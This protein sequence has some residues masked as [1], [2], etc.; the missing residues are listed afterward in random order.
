MTLAFARLPSPESPLRD[1]DP[2]WKL[3]T[4]TLLVG[5][6]LPLRTPQAAG[7]AF[8]LATLLALLGRVPLRWLG[9]RLAGAALVLAPFVLTLPWLMRNSPGGWRAGVEL[10]L[11]VMAKAL[12][13]LTLVLTCLTA[14]PLEATLKAAH[15]LKVPGLLVQLFLLT[16]RYLFLLAEELG[17]LRTALRARGYR[18]RFNRHSYRTVGQ[19]A[20]SLLVRSH[21]RGERVSQAMRC[22]GFD[23]R[24]RC[25]ADFHSGWREVVFL[26]LLA[27]LGTGLLMLDLILRGRFG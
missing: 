24:F 17:R 19:V 6:T 3:A 9:I 20:G 12:T 1:L 7:G 21:E 8:L 13:V 25:L 18:N 5:L 4:F 15:A 10:G 14:A 11:V 22:R 23:G 16:W 27:A 26:V 2:R